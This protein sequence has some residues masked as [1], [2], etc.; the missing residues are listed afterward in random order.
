MCVEFITIQG[1]LAQR[2]TASLRKGKDS[3]RQQSLRVQMME[4]QKQGGD[5]DGKV[6]ASVC[7][8]DVYL[9]SLPHPIHFITNR[10]MTMI[11]SCLI[12]PLVS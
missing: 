7:G 3:H 4:T 8:L 1:T 2:F 12:F 11:L 9:S 10:L 5:G 6:R